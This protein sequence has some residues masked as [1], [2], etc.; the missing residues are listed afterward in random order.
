MIAWLKNSENKWERSGEELERYVQ[1]AVDAK[2]PGS[3]V[4]TLADGIAAV[5]KAISNPDNKHYRYELPGASM[6]ATSR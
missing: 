3:G 5:E 6:A 2:A 4:Y 1:I